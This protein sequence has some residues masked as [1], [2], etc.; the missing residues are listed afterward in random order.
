LKQNKEGME[1]ITHRGETFKILLREREIKEKVK[2]LGELINDYFPKDEELII[3]SLLK[4]SFIFTADLARNIGRT[5]LLL[6]FMVV[7]SYRGTDSSGSINVKKDIEVDIAG[8]NVLLVDDI[9][10]TG[11]TFRKVIELLQWKEP[12]ILKTCVLLDKPER[13]KTLIE[14]DFVGF[15]IPDYFVVGYGLDWDEFGRNLPHIYKMEGD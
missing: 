3:V 4:G 13:R 10:D 14:A 2:F 15:T 12:K 9:L 1:T 6:D 5:N 8:K 11:N 7:S